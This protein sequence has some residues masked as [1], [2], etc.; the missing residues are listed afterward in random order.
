VETIACPTG[1]KLSDWIVSFCSFGFILSVPLASSK[2]VIDLFK[3]RGTDAAVVGKV[4]DGQTLSVTSGAASALLFD[5]E[6]DRDHR[7]HL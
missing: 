5:F 3:E 4:L 7:H 2:A 6:H 1:L